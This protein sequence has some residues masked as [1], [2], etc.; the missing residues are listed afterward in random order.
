MCFRLK[1]ILICFMV[2]SVTMMGIT[3]AED[4][5][6]EKYSFQ[7]DSVSVS[8]EKPN[9]E[10]KTQN[11]IHPII[12]QEGRSMLDTRFFSRVE[13]AGIIWNNEPHG[14]YKYTIWLKLNKPETK[15][16][17]IFQMEFTYFPKTKTAECI[18]NDLVLFNDKELKLPVNPIYK[19]NQAPY[20]MNTVATEAKD[21]HYLLPLRFVFETFGY[22]VNW[23]EETREI[24]VYR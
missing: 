5:F 6:Q 3:R 1:L 14:D 9:Q 2:F 18:T 22:T 17:M 21:T 8:L 12:I 13:F 23:K 7:V 20:I 4:S 24:V 16:E 10:I 11:L 19:G 15:D